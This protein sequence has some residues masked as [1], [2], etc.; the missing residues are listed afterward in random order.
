M[1]N[2]DTTK[3]IA[4][5]DSASSI[6][7]VKKI[8]DLKNVMIITFDYV[9]HKQLLESGIEHNISDD[10]LDGDELQIIQNESFNLTKWYDGELG[11]SL[12]YENINL[13]RIFYVE[14]HHF[15]LQYLKKIL[16]IK[17]ITEKFS[18]AEFITSYKLFDITK[19]FHSSVIQLDTKI[20]K[21]DEFSDDSVRFRMSDSMKFDL[22]RDSYQKLKKSSEKFFSSITSNQVKDGEKSILFVEFD[23]IRYEKLFKTSK[24]HP[25]NFI[26][27]NRRRPSIWN[28]KSYQIIKKSDCI[29]AN[30]DD[31]MNEEMNEKIQRDQKKIMEEVELLW[32]NEKFFELFFVIEKISFWKI[33]K[34]NFI[35]LCSNRM[36]EAIRE[37]NITKRVL[38]NFKISS[39]VCWSENGFNEQIVIGL[40]K[41]MEKE[42]IL[43]Q[44][45]LY[46]DSIDSVYQ[47]EFSGVLP[48]HSN[49]FLVW[50]NIMM[51]YAKN[52]GIP[53][54]KIKIIGSPSYDSIFDDRE[55]HVSKKHVLIATTSTSNKIG[56]FLVKN[57]ESF[58]NII[59]SICKTLKKLEKEIII[60]IHPFEEEEYVTQLV[61]TF[62]SNIQVIKKG[63]IIPLIKSC[64]AL[65]AIDMSTTILEAQIL[66]KPVISINTGKIPFNDESTIFKSNSCD[67]VK[68]EDFEETVGKILHDRDYD[69]SLVRRGTSFLDSYV[70][71]HGRASSE[72]LSFLEK[73]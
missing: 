51:E 63:D 70:S 18:N 50:G 38:E 31:V 48:R 8:T 10:F 26:L 34:T 58:E 71:N 14:F 27:F 1:E 30:A 45:G 12:L 37:I 73:L 24:N 15:L 68:I 52:I 17:K 20:E 5:L 46:A 67:R 62:D 47:N 25:L 6:G 54:N 28:L 69:L 36:K 59:L 19:N 72:L 33:I 66:N 41:K 65:I 29:I 42:I 22:S 43:L 35:R 53:E 55:E 11:S 60:K 9:S 7:N 40:S 44:H 4:F 56:D 57:R 61:K 32:N 3:K 2:S 64:E 23:P 21:N 16:E 13:G 49:N 39:V